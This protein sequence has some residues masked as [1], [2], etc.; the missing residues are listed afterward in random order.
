MSPG[1]VGI[2]IADFNLDGK[3]DIAVDGEILLG[4]GNGTFKGPPTILLPN[5]A[6]IAV[7]GK[8]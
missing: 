6:K 4:N 1:K 5:S 3:P 2:A 8:T 7:V